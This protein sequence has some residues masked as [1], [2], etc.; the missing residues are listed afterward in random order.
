MEKKDRVELL[1]Q[2]YCRSNLFSASDRRFLSSEIIRVIDS[3]DDV[4]TMLS[5]RFNS[6]LQ[7]KPKK[8][9]KEEV[10]VEEK[11]DEK[12]KKEVKKEVKKAVP[13]PKQ[14]KRQV[15]KKT[16]KKESPLKGFGKRKKAN[17]LR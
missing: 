4:E 16:H 13:K 14:K 8:E 17:T 9:V 5:P 12:P 3:D 10:K 1:L 6:K 15:K 7:S 11:S 2:K